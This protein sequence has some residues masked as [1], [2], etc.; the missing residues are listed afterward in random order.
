MSVIHIIIIKKLLRGI[1]QAYL[2][3]TPV[4]GK[5]VE[6]FC[7]LHV[8]SCDVV[9]GPINFELIPLDLYW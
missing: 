5:P 1:L 3:I 9:T 7:S 2:I 8:W 4:K 6:G